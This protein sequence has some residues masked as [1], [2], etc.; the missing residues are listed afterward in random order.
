MVEL[1]GHEGDCKVM[2]NYGCTPAILAE[3]NENRATWLAIDR[4]DFFQTSLLTMMMMVT[5]ILTQTPLLCFLLLHVQ[6]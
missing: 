1:L 4:Y 3:Q 5:S 6:I 2:D